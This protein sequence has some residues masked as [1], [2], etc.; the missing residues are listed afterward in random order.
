MKKIYKYI[1]NYFYCKENY[2]KI[3]IFEQLYIK[4]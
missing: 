2:K 4:Y 1:K 3:I